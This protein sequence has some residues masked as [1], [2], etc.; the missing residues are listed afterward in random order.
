MLLINLVKMWSMSLL[1]QGTGLAE[2]L[3]QGRLTESKFNLEQLLSMQIKALLAKSLRCTNH[4][5]GS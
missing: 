5:D 2:E 4:L 1:R 3:Q